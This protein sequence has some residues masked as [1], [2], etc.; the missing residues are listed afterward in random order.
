M[1]ELTQSRE[2]LHEVLGREA[3]VFAYPFSN[4]S[5]AVR[6]MARQAGYRCA[7]RGQGRM[8]STT[9]DVYGLRRIKIEPTTSI[10]GLKRTLARERYLRLF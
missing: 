2:R 8:N 4:Q 3:D 5:S 7:V 9:T 6:T 1:Y 10:E